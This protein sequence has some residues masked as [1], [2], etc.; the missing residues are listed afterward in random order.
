MSRR[1]FSEIPALLNDLIDRLEAKPGSTRL[2]AY[3]DEEGFGSVVERDRFERQLEQV[4]QMGG[5]Q[6]Q[7][8]RINGDMVIAHVRLA[9]PTA[10][11]EQ[12]GRQPGKRRAADA[13]S[14]L[15]TRANLPEGSQALFDEIES[16][17]ARGVSR[18]GLSP[19]DADSLG[20]AMDLLLALVDRAR[21]VSARSIDFRSFS[22]RAGVDSKG[23]E[24]LSG[25]VTAMLAQ[26]RPDLLPST[27]LD[28]D[29]L[30]AT[31]G[32]SRTPQPFLLSAPLRLS[33]ERLPDLAY[34]GFPPDEAAQVELAASVDYVL[35]IENYVSFVRH[36]REVN[37]DR[38]ALVIYTGGFP[39]R[40]H[41]RHIVRLTRAAAASTFHW[42]DMDAG[43]VRIFR[44][45]E[46][47]LAVQGVS[48]RPHL[49]ELS[50]LREQG[51]TSK[52]QRRLAAGACAG[53]AIAALWDA[54]AEH[55]LSYEQESLAPV[56]PELEGGNP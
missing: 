43:G 12:L 35:T 38:S 53:S 24:R 28:A 5:I 6:I 44:H 29:D 56:R 7:R 42:G 11:Y 17:W 34:Y 14:S 8:R 37:A 20:Q 1:A 21:D 10:V 26:L 51:K 9:D 2:F 33:G 32:I 18:L 49:M 23:L 15:R 36:V 52:N 13:L 19:G 30:L 46:D 39:A 40:A 4:A 25:T 55:G 45:L 22:R 41:L 3:I 27:A 47:A 50:V 54:V 31:F 16:A 48:L